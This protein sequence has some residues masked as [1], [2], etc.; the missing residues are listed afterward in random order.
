MGGMADQIFTL[1][2]G[3]RL[4]VS[5]HGNPLADDVVVFCHPAPGSGV[6]DPDPTVSERSDAHI[7]AIDRPG[8]GSSDPLPVG[9]WPTV[10]RAAEDIAEYIRRRANAAMAIGNNSERTVS[11]VGW[12]A[13][14]RVA[15]AL[16]ARHPSLVKRLAVIGTPAPNDEVEWIPKPLADESAR[17][18]RLPAQEAIERLT[19]A[20]AHQAAAAG[21]SENSPP[22]LAMLGVRDVDDRVL[23]APGLRDRLEQMLADAV[24]QG[25]IGQVTDL[26][27]YTAHPW[28]FEVSNVAVETLLVYGRADEIGQAH[29]EWYAARMP[30]ATLDA[31]DGVGH[32]VVYPAWKRV[33]EFLTFG[34]EAPAL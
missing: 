21:V 27:A 30:N 3:R 26:L 5:S 2:S 33:L 25:S 23:G 12:S 32:L 28:G 4:G 15:L 6:F 24:R 18:A 13:G 1:E 17:L 16:A 11:V 29:G 22:P 10:T 34:Q 14:G 9:E 8:Y 20:F 31:V 7:I 19:D